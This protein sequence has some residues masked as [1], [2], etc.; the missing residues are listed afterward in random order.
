MQNPLDFRG[1]LSVYWSLKFLAVNRYQNTYLH[2]PRTRP[3]CQVSNI[4]KVKCN[5]KVLIQTV[6]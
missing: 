1:I 6:L 5:A 4:T 3:F 2:I